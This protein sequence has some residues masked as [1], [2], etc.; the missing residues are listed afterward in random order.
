MNYYPHMNHLTVRRWR[1]LRQAL[2]RH[3]AANQVAGSAD[4]EVL[5]MVFGMDYYVD[6]TNAT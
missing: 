5:L 2:N 1:R 6:C 3:P 4:T